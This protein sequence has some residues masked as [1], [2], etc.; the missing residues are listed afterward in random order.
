MLYVEFEYR[1]SPKILE[2]QR[3]YVCSD[4]TPLRQR[5][6][7]SLDV[8]MHVVTRQIP[9]TD[10]L[11]QLLNLETEDTSQPYKRPPSTLEQRIKSLR[12]SS[13]LSYVACPNP[14]KTLRNMWTKCIDT[15]DAVR[16]RGSAVQAKPNEDAISFKEV[17]ASWKGAG[18]EVF[19]GLD[20]GVRKDQWVGV[21]GAKGGGKGAVVA[22]MTGMAEVQQPPSLPYTCHAHASVNTHAHTMHV[23]IALL[24]F[25]NCST[26]A[27]LEL[28]CEPKNRKIVGHVI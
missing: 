5:P 25:Y 7:L 4:A 16:E 13:L 12:Q 6:F 22:A 14:F 3:M 10:L 15:G 19:E 17:G 28:D 23:I 8:F 27:D 11:S 20:V 24:R 26:E 21:V 1:V 9:D 2:C 18:E